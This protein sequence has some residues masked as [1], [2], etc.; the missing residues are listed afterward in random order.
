MM[1]DTRVSYAA[2]IEAAIRILYR[3]SDRMYGDGLRGDALLLDDGIG[4]LAEIFEEL[5]G[6]WG[7]GRSMRLPRVGKRRRRARPAFHGQIGMHP[8]RRRQF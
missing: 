6:R 8:T 7:M 2:E 1:S 5:K 3:I 4:G